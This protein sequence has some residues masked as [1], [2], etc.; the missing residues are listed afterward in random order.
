LSGSKEEFNTKTVVLGWI[1]IPVIPFKEAYIIYVLIDIARDSYSFTPSSNVSIS[2]TISR[3]VLSMMN[4]FS[5][6]LRWRIINRT[7]I[8]CSILKWS[9]KLI[10]SYSISRKSNKWQK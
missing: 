7:T 1:L 6:Y 9:P 3:N 5:A 10:P 4:N 8:I 2:P